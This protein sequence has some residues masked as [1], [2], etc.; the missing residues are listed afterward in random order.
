MASLQLFEDPRSP[1]CSNFAYESILRVSYMHRTWRKFRFEK[2]LSC[3][4]STQSRY[5]WCICESSAGFSS[6]VS[7]TLYEMKKV[8]KLQLLRMSI[9]KNIP[10]FGCTLTYGSD[11]WG[12][13]SKTVMH[14]T[15]NICNWS[16]FCNFFHSTNYLSIWLITCTIISSN[17]TFKSPFW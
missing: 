15:F 12:G 3:S 7:W 14:K 4:S 11:I 16:S 1:K 8:R 10:I 2:S 17:I 13:T 5:L 9:I 6:C